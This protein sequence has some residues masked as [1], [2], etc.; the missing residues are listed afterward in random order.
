M[1]I[2]GQRVNTSTVVRCVGNVLLLDGKQYA[3]PYTISAIG[4]PDRLGA[5]LDSSKAIQI[6]KEYVKAD[7]LGFDVKKETKLRFSKTVA[8]TQTLKY[9]AAVGAAGRRND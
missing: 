8:T 2:Q 3:P 9:A 5:A 7:G 6:Y 4:D 1:T